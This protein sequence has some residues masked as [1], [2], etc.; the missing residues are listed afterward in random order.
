[1][2]YRGA[3]LL[4]DSGR[5]TISSDS[6]SFP[7]EFRYGINTDFLKVFVL[8]YAKLLCDSPLRDDIG[9]KPI[10]VYY[11]FIKYLTT[12]PLTGKDGIISLYSGYADKILSNEYV[13]G[14]DSTIGIFHDF[15]LDTPIAR[16]YI[17]WYRT[18]RP[19]LLRYILSFLR[20]GKKLAYIDPS[21]N[22]TAF[23]GWEEVE[24]RLHN[25][26]FNDID[27]SSLRVIIKELIGPLRI[28]HLLPKFGP[29]FVSERSIRDIYDKLDNLYMDT[30]LDYAFNRQRHFWSGK[31]GFGSH[32]TEK[33]S[34]RSGRV[35]R[36]KFV[37][38]DISKSRSI[39]ME[40]NSYMYYQQAVLRWV[41]SS[42]DHSPISRFV[43]LDDQTYNQK[44]AI[45]GSQYLSCDTI[46][47]SSASDSVHIDLVRNVFPRD[48]L[49]YMLSTRTNQVELPDG[50]IRIVKKFAPMGSALCFPTQCI[51][52]TAVCIYA[53]IACTNGKTTGSSTVEV[54]D[55]AKLL[56]SIYTHLSDSTPFRERFEPPVVYGDDLIVDSRVTDEVIS[57]LQRLGFSVNVSKSFTGSQSFR[58]SCGVFA[59]EGEDVTPCMFRLP[60]FKKG[61]WD[62]SVYASIIDACNTAKRFGY[63]HLAMFY[64]QLLE[65]YGF[66]NPIP[67]T[68]DPDS[69]GITVSQK[70]TVNSKYLKYN[71]DYQI[72]FE[73]VQG[74][75]QRKINKTKPE[76][77]D[78]YGLDQWYRSS[79]GDKSTSPIRGSSSI[80][81]KETR[82]VPLWAR[83]E[84]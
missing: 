71:S 49:F 82:L 23:R 25:L 11:S 62:A 70:R 36:L 5:I 24:E 81:P 33:H 65:E 72:M 9:D 20:F 3:K 52:F 64:R 31:E 18:R 16:E 42:I 27:I 66:K 37:P 22:S 47:L 32:Q 80:R 8:S 19:K 38:K 44:A 61:R 79:F 74:I 4:L 53:Y 34:R 40:P 28:D 26:K 48:W 75:G 21:L 55:V 63:Y 76:N 60:F 83:Y 69:F 2:S 43:H 15:M 50:S 51:I 35:S 39:C 77:L 78:S 73:R 58:E 45:H 17:T 41:R 68:T 57:V 30:K 56:N 7:H 13:T 10:R 29:G 1:M 84:L 12:I 54:Y 14:G 59:F 6:I 67:Y 46:D